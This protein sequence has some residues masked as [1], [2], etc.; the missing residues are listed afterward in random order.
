MDSPILPLV[1]VL[2]ERSTYNFLYR[3]SLEIY[4]FLSFTSRAGQDQGGG[5]MGPV[6]IPLPLTLSVF[7]T[8]AGI[9][10]GATIIL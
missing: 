5:A 1:R 4:S 8:I 6:S 7:G 2:L 10:M 9:F 3:L